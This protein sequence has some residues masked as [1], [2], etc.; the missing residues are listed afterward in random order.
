MVLGP[1]VLIDSRRTGQNHDP[2]RDSHHARRTRQLLPGV[3][4]WSIIYGRQSRNQRTTLETDSFGSGPQ[5]P[6]DQRGAK[7]QGTG[8]EKN[9]TGRTKTRK[10]IAEENRTKG[11]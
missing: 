8:G 7:N 9:R 3:K 5:T 4:S 6:I 11:G 1:G 10:E 2:S